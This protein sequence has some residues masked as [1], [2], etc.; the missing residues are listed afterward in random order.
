MKNSDYQKYRETLTGFC[1]QALSLLP[2]KTEG[3]CL[4]TPDGV[5]K[6]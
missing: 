2:V 4:D 1:R 5:V 6:I 3:Y